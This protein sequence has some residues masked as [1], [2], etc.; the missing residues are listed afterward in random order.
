MYKL[1]VPIM[2]K[3]VERYGSEG[4]ISKLKELGAD[5]VVLALDCYEPDE[6]KREHV[7]AS[8]RETVPVFQSAGFSVGVWLCA[9]HLAKRQGFEKRSLPVGSGFP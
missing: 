8:L 7:F 3:Q 9:H 1:S 2:L 4:F 5:T 6:A